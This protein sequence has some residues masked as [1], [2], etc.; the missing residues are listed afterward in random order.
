MRR[1]EQIGLQSDLAEARERLDRI[2]DSLPRSVDVAS[3]GVREKAPFFVLCIR[4][5][6][7]WRCEELGRTALGA[8]KRNDIAAG[9]L[10]ARA[11]LE[12]AA[13]MVRL[14]QVLQ[15]REALGV[16]AVNDT[17]RRMW[18]GWKGDADFPDPINVLTF[19]DQLDREVPGAR[20][21]YDTLSEFAHPNWNGVAGIYCRTDYDQHVASFGKQLRKSATKAAAA[22]LLCG[23]LDT[24][25]SAYNDIADLIPAYLAE[26][27]PF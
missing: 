23:A 16:E 26:L 13:M 10:L 1:S 27:T 22:N 3:L 5:A 2:R 14:R 18:L 6:L 24:M 19:V 21:A 4:E 20:K 9:I 11:L 8:L 25:E 7:I 12:S 15:Q 17:L